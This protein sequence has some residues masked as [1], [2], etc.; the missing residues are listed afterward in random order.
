MEDSVT[1]ESGNLPEQCG[2]EEDSVTVEVFP[3]K[4]LPLQLGMSSIIGTRDSQQDSIFGYVDEKGALGIVCDGMGGL[5]GGELASRQAVESLADAWFSQEEIADIPEF[6]E[7]EAVKADEKVFCQKDGNG[8]AMQAG[9]TIVAAVIQGNELYWLSVGDSK[10]YII[11]EHEILAVSRE[12]NYR[13]TLDWKLGQGEITPEEYAA[14][15]YRAEALI[16]YLGIGNLSLIDVNRKPFLLEEGDIVV[17]SSDGLYKS[18]TEEEILALVRKYDRDMQ[19][20]A[21]NLT[22]AALGDKQSGQDNTSV[23]VLRYCRMGQE[24]EGLEEEDECI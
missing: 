15:E 11:R 17:L 18:L 1:I 12:H 3:K 4:C 8:K 16:S 6:L 21:Q 5:A 10:I 22:V 13:M 14:E 20:C 7:K 2:A 24:K 19:I 9:T 23:V